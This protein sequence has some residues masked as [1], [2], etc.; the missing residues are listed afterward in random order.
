MSS[1]VRTITTTRIKSSSSSIL[2]ISP[3]ATKLPQEQHIDLSDTADISSSYL[4]IAVRICVEEISG[5]KAS[6]AASRCSNSSS[7]KPITNFT[8][9]K[10]LGSS[11]VRCFLTF[12]EGGFADEGF[13]LF[14]RPW[15][16]GG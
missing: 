8:A 1:K 9:S 11:A 7:S 10:V 15:T 2:Q 13:A 14:F 5:G 3:V 12:K 4:L 16:F 6:E